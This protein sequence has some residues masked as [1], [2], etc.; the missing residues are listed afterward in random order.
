MSDVAYYVIKYREDNNRKQH[1]LNENYY[2]DEQNGDYQYDALYDSLEEDDSSSPSSS[3]SS[4]ITS[5]TAGSGEEQYDDLVYYY[6][7]T[8]NTKYKIQSKLKPFT[9]YKFQV[10]AINS[11]NE[12][13]ASSSIRVRTAPSSKLQKQ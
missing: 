1:L 11:L 10:I 4:T 7:N 13:K 5:I 8:T 2:Y 6:E 12:S 3:L 9:Y